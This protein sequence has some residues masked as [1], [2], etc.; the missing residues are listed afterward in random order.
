M[1]S[2]LPIKPIFSFVVALI[3]IIFI[4][5]SN[6][7]ILFFIKDMLLIFGFSVMY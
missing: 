1:P 7:E 4:Y 2:P 6:F 5:L 3:D